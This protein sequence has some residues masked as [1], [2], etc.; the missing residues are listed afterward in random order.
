MRRPNLLFLFTDEQRADTMAAYGNHRIQ[1]PNLNRLAAESTVFERAYVTQPVCTPSRATIMTGL[2]PHTCGCTANNIPLP[3]DTPCL[4]EMLPD[5]QYA[6]AYH[7]K[8]HLGDE[9][10]AQHGFDE[11]RSIEDMYRAHYRPGR[12]RDVVSTYQQWLTQEN[13]LQPDSGDHFGRAAAARLPEQ[14]SK[15][16]Y[17]A[18]EASRFMRENR[19]NPFVLFVNFLEPHM[20]FFGPRDDLHAL[21]DVELPANFETRPAAD[22]A[23]KARLL[24]RLYQ[25]QGHS[26]LPLKTEADWRRMI[27][28]YWGLCSLVDTHVGR[29]LATLEDC[30]L[31]EDTIVVYTSDHG[32]MM[33]SHGLL[34]K[35]VMFEEAV[36][37]PLLVRL[38]GQRGGRRVLEPVSQVDLVPTLLDLMGCATPDC[39]QGQSLR[40]A[41][42]GKGTPPARDVFIEW[43]GTNNGMEQHLKQGRL[44]AALQDMA[45]PEDAWAAVSD[46][47]R[48]VITREGWKLN[49][50][51]LG[52]HELYNLNDDP[53]EVTNLAAQQ[54]MRPTMKN[55]AARLRRWQE[56]TSD[57]VALPSF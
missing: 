33:G 40:P 15:P 49:C 13:G 23:L 35:C 39:L 38:P 51:P 1:T 9:V 48:T 18:G 44:P 29:I 46:P 21:R 45:S 7:G 12:P 54:G 30:G 27:A 16:A 20:P 56:S 36:R 37:V 47:V 52:E 6:T 3:E 57:E 11:W 26:G 43:N 50:S 22:Q 53:R 25:E 24:A 34:A 42:E 31:A 28:N 2:Y 32:D 8:W 5:G 17:L 41:L 55:L 14:Y 4:P 10:F 19:D